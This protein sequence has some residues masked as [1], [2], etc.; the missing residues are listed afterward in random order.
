MSPLLGPL[1]RLPLAP[2]RVAATV[3]G[4]S[5]GAFEVVI[6]LLGA[7]VP[8]SPP[9][10]L[11]LH[12][13]PDGPDVLADALASHTQA[14]VV[15]AEDK[16]PLQTGCVHVAPADYHLLV[17][18][19]STLALSLEAPV[20]YSR[21]SIDVLFDSAAQSLGAR[22]LGILLSGASADGASGLRRL[23]EAGGTALVQSPDSCAAALMPNSALALDAADHICTP[24][25]IAAYLRELRAAPSDIGATG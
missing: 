8:Q 25:E 23:R 20:H 5:A 21:P 13:P 4:G 17:E 12:I 7:L 14:K 6:E 11:V 3:V 15:A 16:Q 18:R 22:A 24:K 9:T 1:P 19:D 10:V 2:G